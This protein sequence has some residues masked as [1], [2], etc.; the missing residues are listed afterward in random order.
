MQ[1][2]LKGVSK[3]F[4]SV[5]ALEPVSVDV[6]PGEIVAVLGAN[7]AGKSTLLRLLGGI[8]VPTAGVIEM[9]GRP[10]GRD[11][12]DLR[13][14]LAFM[15]EFAPVYPDW[16][17]L[18]HI[19]MLLRLYEKEED[20]TLPQRI[21]ALL[22]EF[23][24]LA[25][26]E[27]NMRTLSRGQ[28]YKAALVALLAVDPE[29]WI[30]DEPFATGMDSRGLTAFRRHCQEAAKRGRTIFYSTQLVEVVESLATRVCV[31][32]KGRLAAWESLS[33]LRSRG[34]DIPALLTRWLDKDEAAADQNN[35]P[36]VPS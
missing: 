20:K 16:T 4:G 29:L 2:S 1:I 22:R 28:M 7:G 12:M 33:D 6:A 10:F 23:D 3:H 18:A 36:A 31:V 9:D 26:A 25:V 19:S 5:A 14:K 13:R 17:P 32:N 35:D 11:A 34:E 15:P 27:S 8:L 30:L 21:V 24:L